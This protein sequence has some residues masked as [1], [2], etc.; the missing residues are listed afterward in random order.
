MKN[1]L[2]ILLFPVAALAQP[3]TEIYVFDLDAD[4]GLS[5]PVN[6]S[7]QNPG[8]DNQPAFHEDGILLYV[9]TR[10]DQT[11]VVWANLLTGERRWLTDT[12]GGGEYSPTPAP[13][14]TT[15]SAIRLDTTGLQR[16]YLYHI[17][18]GENKVLV[19]DLVIGYHTWLDDHHLGV[20]VLGNPSTLQVCQIQSDKCR[21]LAE[22]IGRSLHRMPGGEMLS[23]VD[24]SQ[25]PWQIRKM[26]PASGESEMI[27]EAL[28]DSEDVA[29]SPGGVLIS[30]KNS[31]L[32]M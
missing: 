21:V 26:N 11:D 32:Y 19:E 22:N 25:T 30:A 8:Y 31:I 29:W 4:S 23:Y 28:P 6:V 18:S 16:L 24:K 27:I 12:P 15:Y 10:N 7:Q 14:E 5:N 1:F 17:A 3:S 9:A 13:G 20:F 2:L